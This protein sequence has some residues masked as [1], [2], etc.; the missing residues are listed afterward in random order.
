MLL[1]TFAECSAVLDAAVEA[2]LGEPQRRRLLFSGSRVADTLPRFDRPRDQ[3]I[4]DLDALARSDWR[5][6]PHPLL[7]WLERA[8]RLVAGRAQ[9]EV[10]LHHRDLAAQ[11]ASGPWGLRGDPSWGPPPGPPILAIRLTAPIGDHLPRIT[12]DE[13]RSA[14]APADL[15]ADDSGLLLDLCG[16]T[17]DDTAAFRE[18]A[19]TIKVQVDGF[20]RYRARLT[21]SARLAIFG[22]APIPL[23][24]ALGYALGDKQ[25]ALV[26]ERHRHTDDWRW[27]TVVPPASA[28]SLEPPTL[29]AAPSGDVAILLSISD[30]VKRDAV[31][32]AIGHEADVFEI[33]AEQP[34]VNLIRTP[35]QLEAFCTLWRQALDAAHARVG[36]AGRVHV[37]A[38][39]PL[40]VSVE[41]GRRLLPKADPPLVVYDY[42]RG[43]FEPALRLPS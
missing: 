38:A 21:G 32:A 41:M 33:R 18:L 8:S 10:F 25:T 20:V 37:F 19:A 29:L 7:D 34:R 12:L 5:V 11:R 14:C 36:H 43:T 27:G 22:F 3:L 17:L 23:L 24:V 1:L 31:V 39:T 4:G 16:H 13:V 28:L 42:R 6:E 2:G 15:P 40:S 9:A 26:F 35:A 30:R